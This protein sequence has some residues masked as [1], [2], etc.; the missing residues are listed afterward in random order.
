MKRRRRAAPFTLTYVAESTDGS[1]D[2]TLRI[3]NTTETSVIPTLHFR[4]FNAY[5]L[6]LPHV[7]AIGV[8]G[9]HA[10]R[11]V[12]PAG[13]TLVDVL[14]FD[15]Q[16][17]ELVQ[18]VQVEMTDVEE[19]D[20]PALV[21][22]TRSVMIDLDQKATAEPNDFW[23]IGL[24]NPNPFGVTMRVSLVRLEDRKPHRPRQVADVVTLTEDADMASESNHVIWLP[25]DVRGQFDE[26][27]HHLVM[28]TY[29]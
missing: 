25:E 2:Q 3:T 10:G 19:V 11:A 27:V 22:P 9:T 5:G 12:L 6:E 29:A 18:H 15:G 24:V 28:P 1:L 21:Q 17:S 23:G 8:N 13:G 14:R 20:H 16:G 7:T 4:P 26:V